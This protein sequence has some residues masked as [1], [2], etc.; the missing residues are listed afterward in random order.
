MISVR[1]WSLKDRERE[2]KGKLSSVLT[3][4]SKKDDAGDS[5]DELQHEVR[6]KLCSGD[7]ERAG[8]IEGLGVVFNVT[9][10]PH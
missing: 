7:D 10:L 5:L 6:D 4:E 3:D 2:K 9:H 8:L 1:L